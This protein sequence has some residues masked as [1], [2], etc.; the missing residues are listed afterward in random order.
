M[1]KPARNWAC[2]RKWAGIGLGMLALLSPSLVRG[3]AMLQFFN[4]S[5]N[6]IADKV[7][8]LAEAG[9]SSS[10]LIRQHA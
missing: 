3:E 1:M 2:G 8:E 10:S 5:W 4:A 7:P 6:E 9:Y